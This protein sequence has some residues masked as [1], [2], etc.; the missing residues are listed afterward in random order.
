[1]VSRFILVMTS[2]LFSSVVLAEDS[3]VIEEIVVV[4]RKRAESIQDVPVAVSAIDAELEEA[5]VRRLE[6]IQNYSPNLLIGR[7]SGIASG[8]AISIRGVSSNES[9]KSFDI[10]G[11]QLVFL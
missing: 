11:K 10:V 1:M 5:H 2:G 3:A 6:D 8:A 4:A 9:D 7:T